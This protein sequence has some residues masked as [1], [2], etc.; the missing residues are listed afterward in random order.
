MERV[1]V[2]LVDRITRINELIGERVGGADLRATTFARVVESM[3]VHLL[4]CGIVND[5]NGFDSLVMSFNPGVDPKG[6]DAH[7]IL[8]LVGHGAGNVHHV[9]DHGDALGLAY[10]L[11]TSVLFVMTDGHD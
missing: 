2:P 5:V 6:L 7:N 8:L 11:P 1:D 3:L 9:N 4:G 10:F